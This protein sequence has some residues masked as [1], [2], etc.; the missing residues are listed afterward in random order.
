MRP[1]QL[2]HTGRRGQG[3]NALRSACYAFSGLMWIAPRTP[4]LKLAIAVSVGVV[5]LG[6]IF[7][8]ALTEIAILILGAT[9][10]L[11]IE[12]LNTAV[13][14]LCD[15][16]HP[17]PDRRIGRI[18]DVAAAAT[19]FCE[20]GTAIVVLLVLVPHVAHWLGH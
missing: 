7:R 5:G 6:L 10:L 3:W 15:L 11:A 8:L 4:S 20:I 13:E 12:T 2:S 9:L 19:A 14:M 18:K 1:E 17:G 16:L